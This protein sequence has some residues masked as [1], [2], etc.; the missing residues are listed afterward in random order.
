M[1]LS[2]NSKTRKSTG[3]NPWKG[4]KR[5]PASYAPLGRTLALTEPVRAGREIVLAIFAIS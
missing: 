1:L 2:Q 3:R 4:Q 5:V